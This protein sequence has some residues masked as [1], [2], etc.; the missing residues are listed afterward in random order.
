MA[1]P[2]AEISQ[3]P[4]NRKLVLAGQ[5]AFLPTGILPTLL[6]P[7]LPILISRW[8]MNDTQAGNL[9]LVQFLASVVGVQLSGLLLARLGFR[10]ALLSGLL[11]MA[12]G[13]ATLYLGSH[14]LGLVSV[15][16]YG[17]GLGF[18]IP[19]DNLLIAEISTGS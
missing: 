11:L 14:R 1:S 5:L 13:T 18:I 19:T 15:A 4:P 16:V 2:E 9:F 17:L 10:P 6:G 3:P 7:M 12:G 8:A